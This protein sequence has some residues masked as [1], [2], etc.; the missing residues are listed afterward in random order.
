MCIEKNHV[1]SSHEVGVNEKLVGD[2]VKS[3]ENLIQET[4]LLEV[5]T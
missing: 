2:N 1:D 4:N 3:M 5:H